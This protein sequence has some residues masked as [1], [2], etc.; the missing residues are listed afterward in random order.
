MNNF[1]VY[2][3]M[4]KT[5]DSIF[6]VGKGTRYR[7]TSKEGRNPHWHNIVAK[8]GFNAEIVERDLTCEEVCAAEIN[9][10]KDLRDQGIKLC[11]RTDGGEGSTGFRHSE[12]SKQ[13][14]AKLKTGVKYSSEANEKKR[15]ALIGRPVSQKSIDVLIARNKTMILSEETKKRLSEIRKGK[16][17]GPRSEET[18]RK[19]SEAKRAGWAAKKLMQAT[20]AAMQQKEQHV[21]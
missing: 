4:R 14:I 21:E 12:E 6:Y 7:S 20:L 1:Y 17:T 9:L 18:K 10:I 2:I 5:D 3:H 8:N 11:N 13:K 19:M 16:N 15:Q